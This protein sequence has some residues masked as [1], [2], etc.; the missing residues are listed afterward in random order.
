MQ[1][2][3]VGDRVALLSG[4]AYAEHDFAAADALV[5][6]PP[7]LAGKPFPGEPL[8]CAMNIFRRSDIQPGQNVAIVGVGFL[9]AALTALAARAGARVVALSRRPFA[10]SMAEA[11]RRGRGPA[12]WMI[13][14]GPSQQARQLC[15]RRWLRAGHRMCRLAGGAGC[16]LR[17]Y[18]QRAPGS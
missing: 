1:G 5:K 8:A 10:L 11:A 7:Q 3:A 13:R 6:L 15:P 14:R 17:A 2:F 12:V 4:H 9:G 18:R 16:R